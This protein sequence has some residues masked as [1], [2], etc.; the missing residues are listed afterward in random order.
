MK[1]NESEKKKSEN[2]KKSE[3][4]LNFKSSDGND[5]L[6]DFD[7]SDEANINEKGEH[8]NEIK[9]DNNEQS[10]EEKVNINEDNN[11]QNDE[12]ININEQNDEKNDDKK[13]NNDDDDDDEYDEDYDGE[14]IDYDVLLEQRY[15][16]H[17]E[18]YSALDI[19]RDF[20]IEKR[21][22]LSGGT[23]LDYLLR[24]RGDFLYDK[25]RIPDYDFLSPNHLEDSCELASKL[26]EL[27]YVNVNV[28][29][30]LHISSRRVRCNFYS[31]ADITYC[32]ENIFT[33][34][35]VIKLESGILVRG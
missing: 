29:N 13:D 33:L 23:G 8:I 25:R 30:A 4:I 19:V 31:V 3:D 26:H 14:P 21:L 18:V 7:I 27:E 32:P 22:I 5:I 35:P 10:N 28:V 2:D 9:I 1:K 24:E 34:I 15:V 16:F 20:I 17:N 11:E 12:K 6:F